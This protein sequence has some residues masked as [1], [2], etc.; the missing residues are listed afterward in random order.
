M[1]VG[2]SFRHLARRAVVVSNYLISR[3]GQAGESANPRVSMPFVYFHVALW[4]SKGNMRAALAADG[5]SNGARITPAESSPSLQAHRFAGVE[6]GR[7]DFLRIF[8]L[9][10]RP[11]PDFGTPS[12]FYPSQ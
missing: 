8:G 10:F 5:K 2:W 9:V 11:G 4:L 6:A 12:A 7:K 1:V 3:L